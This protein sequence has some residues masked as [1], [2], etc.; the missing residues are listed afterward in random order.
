MRLLLSEKAAGTSARQP[1]KINK[2]RP[3]TV[4]SPLI[5]P[6]NPSAQFYQNTAGKIAPDAIFPVLSHA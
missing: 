3:G 4:T 2:T 5:R 1:P 6:D